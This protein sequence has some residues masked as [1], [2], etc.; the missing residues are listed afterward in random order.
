MG[1]KGDDGRADARLIGAKGGYVS[2]VGKGKRGG[3]L[4]G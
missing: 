4:M 3:E 2:D 1:T